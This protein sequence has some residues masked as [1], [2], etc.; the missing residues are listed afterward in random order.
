MFWIIFNK[1]GIFQQSKGCNN[2]VFE[3]NLIS[4]SEGNVIDFD[5]LVN[6]LTDLVN[7]AKWLSVHLRTK[8]GS[9]FE[10]SCSHLNFR[11]R[12]CLE[13]GV[14][15]HSGNYRVWIHTETHTWNDKNIQSLWCMLKSPKTNTLAHG[16]IE[17]T[18]SML[19]KI[20]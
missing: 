13:Q 1:D 5:F 20:E 19:D 4:Q 14:P 3:S 6:T 12:A 17:R 7:L 2:F 15:W 11:F 9:G 16:L 18:S 8:S 10:S